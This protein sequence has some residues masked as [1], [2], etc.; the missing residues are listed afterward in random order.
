MFNNPV[1]C[2]DKTLKENIINITFE[3]E[4]KKLI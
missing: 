1:I 4:L 2:Y 3:N